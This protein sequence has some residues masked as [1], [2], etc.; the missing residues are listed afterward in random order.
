MVID[1][2]RPYLF[3]SPLLFPFSTQTFF[4]TKI[5]FVQ[6]LIASK[7][8]DYSKFF[9]DCYNAT[10]HRKSKKICRRRTI[11]NRVEWTS[12]AK[13]VFSFFHFL[14]KL[15]I[16]DCVRQPVWKITEYLKNL[17]VKIFF[18]HWIELNLMT[19][20]KEGSEIRGKDIEK[21]EK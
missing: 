15:T 8:F 12:N 20:N 16:H 9:L 5:D 18:V 19:K 11:C 3:L 1:V 17:R 13:F 7:L 14:E 4:E 21:K 6:S 10:W 2:F